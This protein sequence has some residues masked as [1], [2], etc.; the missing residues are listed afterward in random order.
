MSGW[1]VVG[2]R[3][4]YSNKNDNSDNKKKKP[5]VKKTV[6]EVSQNGN[7]ARGVKCNAKTP[8]SASSTPPSRSLIAKETDSDP[9]KQLTDDKK[10]LPPSDLVS[11]TTLNALQNGKGSHPSSEKKPSKTE[12]PENSKNNTKKTES[13]KFVLNMKHTGYQLK[14]MTNRSNDCYSNSVLQALLSCAPFLNAIKSLPK[15][16]H[17]NQPILSAVRTVVYGFK[18]GS[19]SSGSVD[20]LPVIRA[21]ASCFSEAATGRQAD[22]SEYLV[23]LFD[24]L[25][26]ELA[27]LIS[28]SSSDKKKKPHGQNG[29]ET[30]AASG[31]KSMG[32]E[33]TTGE[34]HDSN[35]IDAIFG[36]S[37]SSRLAEKGSKPSVCLQPYHI[38]P[39]DVFDSSESSIESCLLNFTKPEI[40]ESRG[41]QSATKQFV[42]SK[43]PPVLVICIKR[44]SSE[45]KSSLKI[46]IN[47]KL[48]IHPSST[49]TRKK[50]DYDLVAATCHRGATMNSGHYTTVLHKGDVW[51]VF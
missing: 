5:N 21:M 6:N 8:P 9:V 33:H 20:G 3:N 26:K 24:A 51:Y 13:Y 46:G 42:F 35:P 40:V 45:G 32:V 30:V 48:T 47:K 25:S 12:C 44:W 39:L 37:V 17:T 50:T 27:S 23:S 34:R 4:H 18:A 41:G 22:A 43:L 15:L 28:D 16:S 31:T 1:T 19:F 29:W 7:N 38:V 49:V 10:K 2:D 14:G 11:S 36:A